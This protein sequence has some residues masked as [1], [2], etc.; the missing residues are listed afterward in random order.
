MAKRVRGVLYLLDASPEDAAWDRLEPAERRMR[1]LD[2]C[3][4]LLVREAQLAGAAAGWW[5]TC[6]GSTQRPRR[7]ST[8]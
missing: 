7:C 6:T 5:R 4:R 2:A 3:K 1:I 8:R